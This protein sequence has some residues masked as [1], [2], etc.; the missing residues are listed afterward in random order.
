[1]SKFILKPCKTYL[2]IA[3]VC[4][5]QACS[6][7]RLAYNQAPS[8]AY[9]WLDGYFDFN[10]QQAPQV[11]D[12]IAKLL[13]W[14][15]SNELPQYAALL[16]KAQ[17]LAPQDIT[18][19]QA[20]ALY[21]EGRVFF[22]HALE[23]A[24]PALAQLAP[25][26]SPDQIGHLERKYQKNI[27]E[28]S[29]DYIKATPEKRNALRIK[30]AVE[31]SNRIY[32]VLDEAQLAAIQTMIEKSSFNAA[33]SVKDRQRRQAEALAVLRTIITDKPPPAQV[34]DMLRGY[35]SRSL[36]SPDPAYRA[37]AEKLIREGCES[38]AFVHASTTPEQRA[39]AI[40]TLKGYEAD[41][42]ALAANP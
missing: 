4:L 11:R 14:H 16:Q 1:M 28:F 18:P 26:L 19:A 27:A 23:R 37:Y 42:R 34:Q 25:T 41:L 33:I 2:I 9:W 3:V 10:D 29:R 31:R 12:E 20:C 32:G 13:A 39:K 24:L 22:D 38:F 35:Y 15:R 30:Q 5:L 6:T 40:K 21:D 8:L 17:S 36:S 7:I